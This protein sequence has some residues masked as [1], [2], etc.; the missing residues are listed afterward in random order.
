MRVSAPR[1]GPS[2][3]GAGHLRLSA[4]VSYETPWRADQEEIWFD[5]PRL[6]EAQRLPA[7][8]PWLLALLPLAATL[9][10]RLEMETP[11]DGHLLANATELLGVWRAWF[12]DLNGTSITADRRD[13]PPSVSPRVGALFSGG[14]DSFYTLLRGRENAR[15]V[16]RVQI[17]DLI[18]IWGFDVPL[19]NRGAFERMIARF[20]TVASEFGCRLLPVATNLRT[21]RWRETDW[22]TLS[23]GC[24]LAAAGHALGGA[25]GRLLVPSGSGYR[26][27]RPWGS[28][29][30]TDPLMSSSRLRIVHDAA[31]A[32]R[33]D[34]YDAVAGSEVALR[35]LRVCWRSESDSNCGR[36]SKCLRAMIALELRDTLKGTPAFEAE[37]LRL[38]SVSR[39]PCVERRHA[40]ELEAHLRRARSCGRG[41]LADALLAS[42]RGSRRRAGLM[43]SVGRFLPPAV[44]RALERSVWKGWAR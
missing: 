2:T 17:D 5:V 10:E 13:E 36:C 23:H 16:E 40:A 24:G 26:D 21:T 29:V 37:R 27:L 39:I 43:A 32:S 42:L 6:E 19:G 30:V 31:A 18:T 3:L 12:P 8:D 7:S 4:D 44:G 38:R 28:H 9:G 11:I 22:A 34:K 41:D 33:V 14:V 15:P 1:V 25:I 20:R 35:E